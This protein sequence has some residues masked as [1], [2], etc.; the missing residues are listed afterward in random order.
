MIQNSADANYCAVG[1][2]NPKSPANVG[3]IVRACGCFS[4]DAIY[5]TGE[6]YDRAARFNTDTKNYRE[7]I[8]LDHINTF[9]AFT[10][11][12]VK[13]V[14]VE[15]VENAIPLQNFEHPARALYIFG[16]ED[17]S[18]QQHT[19][20]S[21]DHVVFIATHGCLNLSTS[22][23]I[24]LYDRSVKQAPAITDDQLNTLI[25]NSRDNRNMLLTQPI[26][27]DTRSKP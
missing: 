26:P 13:T 15:L 22:V 14:C 6:R 19:I 9:D 24:I 8:T 16:P 3:S 20:D 2:V 25:R 18:L 27:P 12:D 21:A 23:S 7:N 17:H 11:P 5:Y 4:A 10:L 1:L